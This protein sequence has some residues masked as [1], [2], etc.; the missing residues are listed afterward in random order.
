MFPGSRIIKSVGNTSFTIDEMS[1]QGGIAIVE[2]QVFLW[3]TL[4]YGVGSKET[5]EYTANLPKDGKP[6]VDD[7]SSIFHD[8]SSLVR[9][10]LGPF[11]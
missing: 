10:L 6:R 1:C 11:V 7:P 9:Y 8:V 4:Q 3:D 2:N 5:Q